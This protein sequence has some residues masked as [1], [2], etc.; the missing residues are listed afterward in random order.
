M[1]RRLFDDRHDA[2]KQLTA[3][4]QKYKNRDDVIVVGLLRGGIVVAQ[5]IADDLHVPLDGIVVRKIGAPVNQEF[6]VGALAPDG[7]VIVNTKTLMVL[8]I[9]QEDLE[10]TIQ[11]ERKE[12]ARREMIYRNNRP[13]NFDHKIV[14]LV[15]DGIATGFTMRAAIHFVKKQ[16]IQRLIVAVP[17]LP[18]GVLNELQHLVDEVIYV[19]REDY[20]SAIS[21][22]Y[23][24][25][26]QVA[27]SEVVRILSS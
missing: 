7:M 3:L 14:I 25:F 27:D 20:L 6:A 18:S 23:R 1:E 24:S 15:D 10:S 2:G 12:L 4:L 9:T 8:G 16:I 11:E 5:E 17:V 26:E 19:Y 22:S 13:Y 21:Q